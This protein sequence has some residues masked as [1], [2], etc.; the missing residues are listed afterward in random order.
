MLSKNKDNVL[1]CNDGGD[2]TCGYVSLG[3]LAKR[4][5]ADPSSVRRWL[6]DAG[7]EAVAFS[8][9]PRSAIRFRE[10]EVEAWLAGRP[11]VR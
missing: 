2:E 4:F 11:K 3:T 8:D 9:G 6:R 1:I 10:T 7:V 5:D